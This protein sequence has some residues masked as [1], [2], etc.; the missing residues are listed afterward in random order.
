MTNV[1]VYQR[2][3]Y[4][5]PSDAFS[6]PENDEIVCSPSLTPN[7]F[8]LSYF[9]HNST[10]H[11]DPDDNTKFGVYVATLRIGDALHPD[12]FTINVTF[13]IYQNMPS[14]IDAPIAD[15][16]CQPAHS[17]FSYSV[18][19]SLMNEPDNEEWTLSYGIVGPSG[20]DASWFGSSENS[21]HITYFGTPSNSRVGNYTVTLTLDDGNDDV[22]NDT[23]TFQI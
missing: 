22:A 13:E 6:D 3:T 21:T 23:A 11:G 15:Q 20:V 8:G 14:S 18:E 16:P 5:F 12:V 10:F 19:K 4:T 2:F 17:L 1:S 7:D 9:Q